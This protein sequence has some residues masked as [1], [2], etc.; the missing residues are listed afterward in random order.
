MSSDEHLRY[1]IG[2][3]QPQ[4]QYTREELSRYI[5]D[6][7]KLPAELQHVVAPFTSAD[8]E[9]PYRAGGWTARQVVVHLPDSHMNAYVRCKW[10]LTEPS[11]VIK[12]YDEKGWAETPD[13]H[14]DPSIAINLLTALHTKW[15]ALLSA[16]DDDQLRRDFIHPDT[17]RHQPLARMVATYAWHGRHHL[18]HL[19]IIAAKTRS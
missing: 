8:W 10:A 19:Q 14:A 6:I 16:L 13:L 4:E 15:V 12:A 2:R 1:P 17:R 18:A 5:H 3:F 7:G 11:P 9:V